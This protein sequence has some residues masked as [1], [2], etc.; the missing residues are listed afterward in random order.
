MKKM[1][2]NKKVVRVF[3]EKKIETRLSSTNSSLY[4]AK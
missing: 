4:K 1:I 3:K 2:I